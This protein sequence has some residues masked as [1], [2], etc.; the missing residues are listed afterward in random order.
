MGVDDRLTRQMRLICPQSTHCHQGPEAI[1][2]MILPENRFS[3][4]GIML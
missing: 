1:L 2:S 3:L 4:L